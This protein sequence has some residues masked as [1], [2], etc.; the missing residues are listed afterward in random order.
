MSGSAIMAPSS[1]V[2]I[3]YSGSTVAG[4]GTEG[5]HRG[6]PAMVSWRAI[7]PA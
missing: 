2:T 4:P 6:R 1:A 7:L 3:P 5:T